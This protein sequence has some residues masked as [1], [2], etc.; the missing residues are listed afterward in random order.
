[1]MSAMGGPSPPAPGAR[2][3][4]KYE[5]VEVLG[6]G[7]MGCVFEGR[8]ATLGHRVAI[9]VL[10]EEAAR[11]PEICRRFAREARAVATLRGKHVARVIDVD[12]LPD[13]RPYMVMEHLAG[14]D[15]SE[16][17]DAKGCFPVP[18]AVDLVLQ[19]CTAIAEAHERGIIHRDLK[20]GNLFLTEEDG[21]PCLK[22][23]DFG[24][25]K[26]EEE[27]EQGSMTVTATAFGTP[28]YMSPEQIR[29]AKHVDARTDVWSLAV[30]LYELLTG[31]TP[32]DGNSPTAVIAAITADL[33]RPI[34]ELRPDIPPALS[35]AI[36]RALEKRPDA[37]YPSALAFAEAIA[38]FS[39]DGDFV[40][41]SPAAKTT[42]RGSSMALART[43]VS[44]V[45]RP[46]SRWWLAGAMLLASAGAAGIWAVAARPSATPEPGMSSAVEPA[47]PS[48]QAAAE[49]DPEVAP[50]LEPPPEDPTPAIATAS[51]KPPRAAIK[52]H[53]S[54]PS[55]AP[56]PAAPP[57]P[58]PPEERPAP[59]PPPPPPDDRPLTL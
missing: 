48:A 54:P 50:P 12:T 9:K 22:L 47:S 2:L 21:A 44:P 25:S 17:L 5:I 3:G 24:I 40:A 28:L 37:R 41:P 56:P 30:I 20:P 32:F 23:L 15:L 53:P 51:S 26:V 39:S 14:E 43:L 45:E 6:V 18:E 38:P 16:A 1:M 34:E 46:R 52:P 19:A 8:H 11:D 35:A 4:D 13:G 31:Q 10:H 57:S 55:V 27:N 36:L 42:G 33:P 7:G 49:G 58:R 59:K 29:S